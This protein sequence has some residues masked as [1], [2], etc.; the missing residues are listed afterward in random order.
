MVMVVWLLQLVDGHFQDLICLALL[1]SASLHTLDR[2]SL[3]LQ[4]GSHKLV[5]VVTNALLLFPLLAKVGLFSPS[6]N[7]SSSKVYSP[8]MSL[9]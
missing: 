4:S 8:V 5:M 1:V 6:P 9:T 2:D 3:L 7:F